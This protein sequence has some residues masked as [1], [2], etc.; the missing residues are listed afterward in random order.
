MGIV[1]ASEDPPYDPVFRLW[2][3]RSSC[4][5]VYIRNGMKRRIYANNI[6]DDPESW[7]SNRVRIWRRWTTA[8]VLALVVRLVAR[9]AVA[10]QRPSPEARRI[11]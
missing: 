5:F 7:L 8:L 11:I 10:R 1:A 2:Y 9:L 3:H 4:T 6:P